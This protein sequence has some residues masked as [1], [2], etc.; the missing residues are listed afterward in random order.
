MTSYFLTLASSILVAFI[1][2]VCNII[3][4]KYQKRTTIKR[5]ILETKITKLLM[6]L[7]FCLQNDQF[8]FSETIENGDP[9]DY[10]ADT[11]KRLLSKI[12]AIIQQYLY[13]ADDELQKACIDFMKW[14]YEADTQRRFDKI[15]LDGINDIEYDTFT[16][17]VSKKYMEAKALY[18]RT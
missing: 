14:A 16:E 9:A 17:V 18:H 5:D 3:Y 11:P 4:F 15:H 8:A 6:P 10:I 13:L 12:T 1:G 2:V 7:Y